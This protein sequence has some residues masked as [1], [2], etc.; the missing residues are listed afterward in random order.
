MDCHRCGRLI[1]LGEDLVDVAITTSPMPEHE[2]YIEW[3]P[4]YETYLCENC[5]REF[6]GWMKTS[7]PPTD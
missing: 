2:D 3:D 6:A 7:Y 5:G 4:H 1:G